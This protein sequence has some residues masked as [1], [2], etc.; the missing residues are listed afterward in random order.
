VALV[1]AGLIV[2]VSLWLLVFGD[3]E[4]PAE[5]VDAAPAG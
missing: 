3:V 4:M 5:T 2:V 1:V